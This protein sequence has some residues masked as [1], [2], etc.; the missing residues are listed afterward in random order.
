MQH[1]KTI[2]VSEKDALSFF[3]D[4]VKINSN[5]LDQKNGLNSDAT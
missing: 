5:K 1:F 4:T 3:I 2:P